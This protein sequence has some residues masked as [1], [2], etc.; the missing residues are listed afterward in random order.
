M[1]TSCKGDWHQSY[2]L[3]KEEQ[4]KCFK[5]IDIKIY[6]NL[7]TKIAKYP[8]RCLKGPGRSAL[9]NFCSILAMVPL[10]SDVRILT[11]RT[12]QT[13]KTSSEKHSKSAPA[14]ASLCFHPSKRWSAKKT[15]RTKCLRTRICKIKK[16]NIG[17]TW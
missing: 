2:E 16:V 6:L 17:P 7:F 1:D 8:V 15:K 10:S 14:A 12:R 13:H 4:K 11:I 5:R 9:M 3:K